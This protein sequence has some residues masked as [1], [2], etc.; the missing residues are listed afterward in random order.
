MVKALARMSILLLGLASPYLAWGADFH[1]GSSAAIAD[2]NS[3]T[4]PDF[5]IADR[6]GSGAQGYTAWRSDFPSKPARFFI[7]VHRIRR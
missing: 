5:A 2:F 4:K 6:I 1:M 7:S 3:D